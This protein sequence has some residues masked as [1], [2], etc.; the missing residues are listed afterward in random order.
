MTE[1]KARTEGCEASIKANGAAIDATNAGMARLADALRKELASALDSMATKEEL[2]AVQNQVEALKRRV[3]TFDERFET[4][5]NQLATVERGIAQ[6]NRRIDASDERLERG[7]QQIAAMRTDLERQTRELENAM[8][9]LAAM[10]ASKAERE[11]VAD[12]LRQVVSLRAAVDAIDLRTLNER[13]DLMDER[14]DKLDDA[15]IEI[16][17]EVQVWQQD[18]EDLQLEKQIET[19]RRE[20][21]EAKTGV[22]VKATARMDNMQ[23]ETEDLRAHLV[24]AQGQIQLN[25]ENI[26]ELEELAREGHT[27]HIPA[28]PQKAGTRALFDQLQGDIARLELRYSE[29]AKREAQG[30]GRAEET[31]QHLEMLRVKLDEL[32]Q[33]KADRETVERALLI[34]A[35]KETL[36]RDTARNL[37]AVDEALLAMNQG[38]Q[39][40]QRLLER[41]E[42]AMASLNAQLA[43]KSDREEVDRIK[44]RLAQTHA[45]LSAEELQQ[46]AEA[47]YSA[48]LPDDGSAAGFRRPLEP[49]SCISCNRPL[50]SPQPAPPVP[51]LE[52]RLSALRRSTNSRP[53]LSNGTSK[54]AAEVSAE[55]TRTL[56]NPNATYTAP[57]YLQ[58]KSRSALAPTS[59]SEDTA[60][61]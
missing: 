59:D 26:E 14:C 28:G 6:V 52:G 58:N 41:Q 24:N 36:A 29:A 42:G 18:M 13:I 35:D 48:L 37:R 31:A 27:N 21:A 60:P 43:T 32:A 17:R 44:Q 39:G 46:R 50:R 61:E 57:R 33:A 23:K 49:Y 30:L 25:R 34:K 22:F 54:T 16:R 47:E 45:N 19:L 51:L 40:V 38:T 3:D 15:Q 9:Q 1:L 5:E 56:R 10:A 2:R 11:E 20:L 55:S 8:D 12:V 53:T 4:M 7:L